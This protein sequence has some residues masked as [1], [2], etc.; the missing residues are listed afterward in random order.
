MVEENK[1]I[2]IKISPKKDE[3]HK[4]NKQNMRNISKIKKKINFFFEI[5]K[6]TMVSAEKYKT[7]D[8]ITACELNLCIQN[9]ENINNNL[10]NLNDSI[11]KSTK[12][13]KQVVEKLQTIND[14]ISLVFKSFGTNKIENILN[15]CY[16]TDYV[17]S[18]KDIINIEK[19][20]IIMNYV[21]PI[22]YKIIQWK[23]KPKNK[24][25]NNKII[26]NKIIEDFMI[27]DMGENLDCYDLCRTSNSFYTK[28]YGIKIVFQNEKDK[29]T[30]I[31]NGIVTEI[32]TTLLNND[33]INKR[34]EKCFADKPKDNEFQSDIFKRIFKSFNN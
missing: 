31:I 25:I 16:G 30:M 4:T 32:L 13:L 11:K 5:I 10:K 23:N 22:S 15:V 33:F 27:V 14:E 26:K 9:L 12:N 20:K 2:K 6:D 18:I 3:S 7:N 17:N 29:N 21:E 24:N 34:L 28:V 8:I 19:F 1:N